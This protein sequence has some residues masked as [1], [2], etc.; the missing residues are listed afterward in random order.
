MFISS[1]VRITTI[2]GSW[3]SKEKVWIKVC[4]VKFGK[5]KGTAIADPPFYSS[6]VKYAQTKPFITK[7]ITIMSRSASHTPDIIG[8]APIVAARTAIVEVH[9]PCVGGAD[10][11]IGSR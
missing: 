11:H 9:A 10:G 3:I 2:C 6:S 1:S 7:S 5:M 8:K 4:N